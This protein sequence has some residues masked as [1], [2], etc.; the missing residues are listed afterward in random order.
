MSTTPID[1]LSAKLK[2]LLQSAPAQD[3]DKNLRAFITGAFERMDLVTREDF[4]IQRAL[5]ERAQTRLKELEV[6]IAELEQRNAR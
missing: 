5:L 2:A 6:R 4:E 3:L 1:E